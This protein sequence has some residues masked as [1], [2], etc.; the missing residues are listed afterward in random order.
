[1]TAHAPASASP[2]SAQ[3]VLQTHLPSL[4]GASD[5]EIR[6]VRPEQVGRRPGRGTGTSKMGWKLTLFS[7]PLQIPDYVEVAG[8]FWAEGQQDEL[9]EGRQYCD[10]EE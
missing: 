1:M 7:R 9:E 10:A 2:P 6:R 4:S 3:P 5:L 8:T